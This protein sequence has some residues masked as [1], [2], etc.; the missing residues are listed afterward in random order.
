MAKKTI[1]R[2]QSGTKK[3]MAKLIIPVKSKKTGY[4]SFDERVV[5]TEE[6]KAILAKPIAIR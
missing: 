1:A 2:I 5:N 4:Y 6:A 3:S